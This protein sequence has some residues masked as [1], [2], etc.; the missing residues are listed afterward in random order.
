MP[1][2]TPE[3]RT[4]IK[5]MLAESR[6]IEAIKAYREFTGSGLKESKD[7]VD[8]YH[9]ELAKDQPELF[10]RKTGGCLGM[11]LLVISLGAAAGIAGSTVTAWL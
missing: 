7:W 3:Q 4:A 11:I 8:A 1:E 2:L 10:Q 9:Q 5:G 6:I